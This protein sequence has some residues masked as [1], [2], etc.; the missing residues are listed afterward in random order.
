MFAIEEGVQKINGEIVDTFCREITDALVKLHV[1]A[2]TTGYAD[3]PERDGGGRTYVSIVC[4]HGDFH[5]EPV[6]NEKGQIAGVKIACCGDGGL[7]AIMKA[8]AFAQKA[9]NDLI[10]DI[11]G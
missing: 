11:D 10:C 9:L 2:G 8:L 4:D 3:D 5:F 1:E 7:S 6:K